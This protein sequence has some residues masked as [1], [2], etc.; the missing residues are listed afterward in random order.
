MEHEQEKLKHMMRLGKSTLLM[1]PA[2][3]SMG[4]HGDGNSNAARGDLISYIASDN[5]RLYELMN[6]EI[7]QIENINEQ[8]ANC[9][10]Q[11]D[12]VGQLIISRAQSEA[13]PADLPIDAFVRLD[14]NE[15]PLLPSDIS[16]SFPA[17]DFASTKAAT[18]KGMGF[19]LSYNFDRSIA[20]YSLFASTK[21]ILMSQEVANFASRLFRT[22]KSNIDTSKVSETNMDGSG[23]LSHV[24]GL[25]PLFGFHLVTT[26]VTTHTMSSFFGCGKGFASDSSCFDGGFVDDNNIVRALLVAKA[27]T[28]GKAK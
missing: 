10:R 9:V 6:I 11:L 4:H 23:R 22:S 26:T 15:T 7:Q 1:S 28:V 24:D 2:T 18:F 20:P 13:Q 25:R 8:I 19:D 3:L 14:T 16:K 5:E 17:S 12:R 27:S 21:T